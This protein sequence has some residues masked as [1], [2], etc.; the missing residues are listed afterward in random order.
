MLRFEAPANWSHIGGNGFKDCANFNP[1]SNIFI[2]DENALCSAFIE[3]IE[4]VDDCVNIGI[5]V[6]DIDKSEIMATLSFEVRREK[7]IQFAKIL[8]ACVV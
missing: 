4:E 5:V 2:E 6:R 7:A 1:A 3:S 8:L